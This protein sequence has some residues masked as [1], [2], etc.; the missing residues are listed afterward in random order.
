MGAGIVDWA[1]EVI[2]LERAGL[3][4]L[5]QRADALQSARR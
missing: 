3:K 2:A 1:G 4:E 5:L